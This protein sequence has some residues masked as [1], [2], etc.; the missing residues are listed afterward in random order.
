[1]EEITLLCADL[2]RHR[3][4]LAG[5]TAL[6]FLASL[7]LCTVLTAWNNAGAYMD[8][9]LERAGFGELTAWVSGAQSWDALVGEIAA[10]DTVDAVG[11]QP[12]IYT[13]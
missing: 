8:A 12:V 13:N 7:V 10:L 5:I 6:L 1:M 3:G 2:R 4:G 11:V 9:E